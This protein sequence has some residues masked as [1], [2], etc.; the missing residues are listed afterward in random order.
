[1]QKPDKAS[2]RQL[3]QLSFISQFVN[4]IKH[5]AGKNNIAAD[6]LSRIEA[7]NMPVIVSTQDIT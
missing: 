4:H 3:R 1:M 7:I 2:P 6:T 5:V